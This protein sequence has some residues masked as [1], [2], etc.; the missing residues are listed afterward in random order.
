M[1]ERKATSFDIAAKAGVS[2][3]TV[4]RALRD[5]PLVNPETRA[6]V[7]AIARE[8][9]YQVDRTASSLRTGHTRT[10]ALLLFED[11]PEDA[12]PINPF[13]LSMLGSITK[14]CSAHDYDLLVSFQH[15]EEDW[16]A[17]YEEAHRADGL[18]LLGYGDYVSAHPTLQRLAD[19]GAH[20]VI[21]GPRLSFEHGICVG[22]DNALGG[23]QATRHLLQKGRRNIA[24]LGCN[25]EQA[26]EFADRFSGYQKALKEARLSA[27]DNLQVYAESFEASGASA[28]ASL[29]DAG[30]EFDA[31]V[32]ASDLIAI[33][34]MRFLQD[35][36]I[37]VPDDVAIIGFDDI[38][39]AAYC[40]PA[41][42]TVRQDVKRAG[43]TMVDLL[44]ELIEN[45][46]ETSRL[47][48]PQLIVRESCGS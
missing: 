1:A 26:P 15:P 30:L 4:S 48:E 45:G 16:Y 20:W 18:I 44:L 31:L 36:G 17:R 11:A 37:A 46:D 6:R 27:N 21:W 10:L 23:Y 9:N 47:L 13:F 42:T 24:F 3:S 19:S 7:Q 34:A 29:L 28:V 22:S 12:S 32:C 8:L 39:A 43:E 40:S 33:G 25:S 5:S 41:L 14:A 38:Q 35:Q 2:Q